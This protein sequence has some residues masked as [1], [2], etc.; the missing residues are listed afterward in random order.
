MDSC[1]SF[2][3]AIVRARLFAVEIQRKGMPNMNESRK[4]WDFAAGQKNLAYR[5]RRAGTG[6]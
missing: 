3:S 1:T 2:R 4:E 5:G 6:W